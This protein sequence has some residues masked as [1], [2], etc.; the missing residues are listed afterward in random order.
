VARVVETNTRND[1]RTLGGRDLRLEVRSGTP[2]VVRALV[3]NGGTRRKRARIGLARAWR[4]GGPG[5]EAVRRQTDIEAGW[6][7]EPGDRPIRELRPVQDGRV[8]DVE[9]E[10]AHA[11]IEAVAAVR[12]HA[13]E[14]DLLAD[15]VRVARLEA[16]EARVKGEVAAEGRVLL[17]RIL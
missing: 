6:E 8:A 16:V 7:V 14:F 12:Q 15:V 9:E 4:R 2:R 17:E 10:R 3:V 1:L 11:E 5:L 13:R